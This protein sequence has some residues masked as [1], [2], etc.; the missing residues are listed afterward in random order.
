[1]V[2]SG[3]ALILPNLFVFLCL[4]WV[5]G[6]FLELLSFLYWKNRLKKLDR[7][8]AQSVMATSITKIRVS[9][10]IAL[11][12]GFCLLFQ[13]TEHKSPYIEGRSSCYSPLLTISWLGNFFYSIFLF[14]TLDW[15]ARFARVRAARGWSPTQGWLLVTQWSEPTPW[16]WPQ[17]PPGPKTSRSHPIIR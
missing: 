5:M 6:F 11:W 13:V 1:M 15:K 9:A 2:H 17:M 16:T 3:Q 8:I 14:H 4:F 10:S 12:N 7:L